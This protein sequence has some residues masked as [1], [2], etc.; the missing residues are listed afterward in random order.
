MTN[1]NKI[2]QLLDYRHDDLMPLFQREQETL[3]FVDDG[4]TWDTI[5]EWAHEQDA[6]ELCCDAGLDPVEEF[7]YDPAEFVDSDDQSDTE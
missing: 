6:D 7:D 4:D 3:G 5:D 1:R 2:N